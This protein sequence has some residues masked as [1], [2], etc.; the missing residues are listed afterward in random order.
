MIKILIIEDNEELK[1]A[2]RDLLEMSEYEVFTAS[3]GKEGIKIARKILPDLILCD[4][5]MP[6]LD[7]YQVKEEIDKYKETAVIPFIFVTAKNDFNDLRKGM[8][9]GADDYIVKPYKADEL[10]KAIEVRLEKASKSMK[11]INEI[12]TEK[13]LTDDD[14]IFVK[15]KNNPKFVRAGDIKCIISQGNDTN[16]FLK[17]NESFPIR[18][19]LSKWESLLPENTF[20]RVHKSAI[21]NLNFIERISKWSSGTYL[22]HIKD[23]EKTLTISQRYAKEINLQLK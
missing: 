9:K 7:G 6:E 12:K 3:G 15:G 4:I 8:N 20:R 2:E 17:S 18:R 11:H 13:K 23:M 16:V 5:M 1:S 22:I 19:T 10:L 21:V 14:F